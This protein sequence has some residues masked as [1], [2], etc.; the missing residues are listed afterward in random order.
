MKPIQEVYPDAFRENSYSYGASSYGPMIESMAEEVLV[1]K[2]IGSYQGDELALL[3]DN[4]RYGILIFGFG[5]CTVCDSLLS[6]NSYEEVNDLRQRLYNNIKWR[7]S[8]E[9]IIDYLEE[10]NWDN[11]YIYHVNNNSVEDFL[12]ECK[13]VLGG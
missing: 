5:S 11:E 6:C 13:E 10:K 12:E 7:P 2:R 3:K 8:K 4:N 1:R 9:A